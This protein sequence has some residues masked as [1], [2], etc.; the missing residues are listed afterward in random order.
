MHM[1]FDAADCESLHFMGAGDTAEE[2]P[3]SLFKFWGYQFDAVLGAEDAMLI[4]AD[5]GMGHYGNP[6]SFNRPLRDSQIY[7]GIAY[8]AM[9]RC[10]II[11]CPCR[12]WQAKFS[13][14]HVFKKSRLVPSAWWDRSAVRG[15]LFVPEGRMTI[16]QRFIAG[17]FEHGNQ[18]VPVRDD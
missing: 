17:S 13:A 5:E 12:D 2:G 14:A 9:N 15:R 18:G 7:C 4:V 16:A 3:K 1:V 8:P 6:M 11:K 10:A